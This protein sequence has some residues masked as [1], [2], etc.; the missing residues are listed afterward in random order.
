[1]STSTNSLLAFSVLLPLLLINPSHATSFRDYIG[2]ALHGQLPCNVDVFDK[3]KPGRRWMPAL[4]VFGDSLVDSGNNN[5]LQTMAK[6]NYPPYGSTFFHNATGRFTDGR[7]AAD[8]IGII[9]S[10]GA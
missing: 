6:A 8:F 7:T 1:M 9:F 4:F 3:V 10:L 5:F 2:G